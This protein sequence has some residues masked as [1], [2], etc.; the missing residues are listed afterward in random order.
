MK[1]H[2]TSYTKALHKAEP[3]SLIMFCI[4]YVETTESLLHLKGYAGLFSFYLP[5]SSIRDKKTG[6]I[7]SSG[8]LLGA[9]VVAQR[10]ALHVREDGALQE[11]SSLCLVFSHPLDLCLFQP[12]LLQHRRHFTLFVEE[13]LPVVT[14]QYCRKASGRGRKV[15]DTVH[16]KDFRCQT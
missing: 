14:A 11:A 1:M 13:C 16:R 15:E 9:A 7:L 5:P 2:G 6:P 4:L 8:S 12:Q 3:T 10:G